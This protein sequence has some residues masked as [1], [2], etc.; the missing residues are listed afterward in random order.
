[1]Q[2]SHTFARFCALAGRRELAD[3]ARRALREKGVI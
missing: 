3:D 2:P 1:V